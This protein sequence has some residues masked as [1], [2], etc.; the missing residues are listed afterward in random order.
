[1]R[2]KQE[3]VALDENFIRIIAHSHYPFDEWASKRYV[4]VSNNQAEST[5]VVI[6]FDDL[7]EAKKHIKDAIEDHDDDCWETSEAY[8]L[9]EMR[10]LKVVVNISV[11]IS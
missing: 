4:V 5:T 7:E 8:D 6:G 3:L 9:Q 1:M 10:R 11:D 2:T